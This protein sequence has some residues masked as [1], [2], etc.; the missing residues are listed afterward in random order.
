MKVYSLINKNGHPVANQQ[1]VVTNHGEYFVSY[2]TVI[3][4]KPFNGGAPTVSESWDYSATTL[5]HL[6]LF[7]GIEYTKA[8]IQKRLES[9]TIILDKNLLISEAK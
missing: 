3:A 9:G 1:V 5:K 4:Y 6:K 2:S 7:L 8:Q